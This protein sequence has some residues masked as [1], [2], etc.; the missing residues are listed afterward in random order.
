VKAGAAPSSNLSKEQLAYIQKAKK[1]VNQFII[2]DWNHMTSADKNAYEEYSAY[3]YILKLFGIDENA[4]PA[5]NTP[6]EMNQRQEYLRKFKKTFKLENNDKGE[7]VWIRRKKPVEG[8]LNT[9]KFKS[10]I[11]SVA[12][13][14]G[15]LG[16]FGLVGLA[17]SLINLNRA[18]EPGAQKHD[19]FKKAAEVNKDLQNSKK[20]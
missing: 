7:K 3:P 17:Q 5:G 11:G 9:S 10:A 16:T 14:L 12:R 18:F 20:L 4:W 8:E 6:K 15:K 2:A 13:K 1:V 19:L